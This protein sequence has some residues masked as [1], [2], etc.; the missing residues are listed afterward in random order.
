MGRLDR[1][2]P[3][4]SSFYPCMVYLQRFS[5]RDITVVPVN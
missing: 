3:H 5:I 2:T 1:R 4:V